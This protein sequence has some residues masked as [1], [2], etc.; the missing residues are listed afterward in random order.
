MTRVPG[1]VATRPVRV[2]DAAS[3]MWQ[4]WHRNDLAPTVSVVMP[5]LNQGRFLGA[6]VRS[7]LDQAVAGL[8]L[9]VVDGGSVDGSLSQLA[10]LAAQYSGRLRWASAP[11]DGPA[12][13]VNRAVAM[14][15]GQV[16]GWLNSDDLYEPGAIQRALDH[17]AK[18]PANVM[19]YG[20]A[21]HVDAAGAAIGPYPTQGPETAFAEFANGCFICQPSVFV[22]RAAWAAVG[23]LDEGLRTAFDFDLWLKLFKAYPGRIGCLPALQARSRLHEASI[24][25]R[26]RQ[27][28]A[29]E[30]MAVVHRH[31]GAAPPHW[32]LTHFAELCELHPFQPQSVDLPGAMHELVDKA[33]QYLA[34]GAEQLL[35]SRIMEDKPLQLATPNLFAS[36][37]ADGWAGAVMA[38]RLRQPA[39]P[40]TAIAL[41]CRHA[42]PC[43]GRLRIE[44]TAPDTAVL[45]VEID[46]PG[47]FEIV[48]PAADQRP[49]ARAV[50]RVVSQGCF[51][52]AEVEA[53]SSDTRRLA[54]LLDQCRLINPPVGQLPAS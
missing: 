19:V 6:A 25:L 16:I 35:R 52:P 40:C 42:N 33:A 10:A 44:I 37:Y 26:L 45:V 22:R 50:Y 17:L 11:D 15:G 27:S 48:V 32:L 54:F 5:S 3:A 41:H 34:P 49:G 39:L 31:L 7:V 9:V 4:R 51:V 53:G 1:S 21:S 8:E 30:G 24:T 2:T 43:G 47:P 12:Q 36:I 14:A 23:G 28:V 13:A 18:F 46:Q 20:Q 38:L 29:L